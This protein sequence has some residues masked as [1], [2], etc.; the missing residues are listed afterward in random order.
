MN[1]KFGDNDLMLSEAFVED[2]VKEFNSF[3]KNLHQY[4]TTMIEE[5]FVINT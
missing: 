4:T 3:I 1:K 5:N 2:L